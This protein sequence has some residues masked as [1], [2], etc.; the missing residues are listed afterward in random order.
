MGLAAFLSVSV[1]VGLLP[2]SPHTHPVVSAWGGPSGPLSA[3]CLP[4]ILIL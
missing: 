3:I 4:T 2:P 1:V